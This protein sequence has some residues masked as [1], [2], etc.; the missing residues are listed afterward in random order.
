MSAQ[1]DVARLSDAELNREHTRLLNERD[2]AHNRLQ[3]LNRQLDAV[4]RERLARERVVT[5][6]EDQC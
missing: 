5:D 3:H 6:G 2:T 1:S 4:R